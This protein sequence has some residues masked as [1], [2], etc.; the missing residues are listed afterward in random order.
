MNL[1]I[2]RSSDSWTYLFLLNGVGSGGEGQLVRC[3][4]NVHIMGFRIGIWSPSHWLQ[5]NRL[6]PLLEKLPRSRRPQMDLLVI[7]TSL[8]CNTRWSW[9]FRVGTQAETTVTYN[10][11]WVGFAV[12]GFVRIV[13]SDGQDWNVSDNHIRVATRLKRV[14]SRNVARLGFLL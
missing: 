13:T 4:R 9:K 7:P 5:R 1:P 3:E 14:V 8:L 12:S 2:A 6:P 11:F 10:N